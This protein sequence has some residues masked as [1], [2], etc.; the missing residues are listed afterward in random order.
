MFPSRAPERD[1]EVS[2]N[3]GAHRDIALVDTVIS[4]ERHV[5]ARA[6]W[7]TEGLQTLYVAYADPEAIGMSA[8]TA[9]V[10]PV[11]IGRWQPMPAGQNVR[12][13]RDRGGRCP[14]RRT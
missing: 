11:A 10:R 7:R 1:L 2:I 3:D 8:I 13:R 4:S 12:R 6:L 5:G 14:Q 9:M